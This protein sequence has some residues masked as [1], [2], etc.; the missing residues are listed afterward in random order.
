MPYSSIPWVCTSRK[1]AGV[2]WIVEALALS[3]ER[4]AVQEDH[5]D[6]TLSVPT[7]RCDLQNQV[8]PR[9][10]YFWGD[11]REFNLGNRNITVI[12]FKGE[13]GLPAR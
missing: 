7:V 13:A 11:Q 12:L 3:I 2:R 6:Q 10:G 8:N 1:Y 5:R 9:L 4:W